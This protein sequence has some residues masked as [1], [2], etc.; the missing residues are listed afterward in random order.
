MAKKLTISVDDEVYAELHR[1]VGRGRISRFLEDLARPYL[2]HQDLEAAYR[3]MAQDEE[4]EREALE[5]SEGLIG[6]VQDDPR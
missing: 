6:D 3:E 5:W 4:R 2:L 1:T